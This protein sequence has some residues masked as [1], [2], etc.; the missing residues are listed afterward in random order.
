MTEAFTGYAPRRR[1]KPP[2]TWPAFMIVAIAA[3][4]GA[5]AYG[6]VYGPQFSSGFSSSALT[7]AF[8]AALIPT[9]LGTLGFWC[10]LY[11]GYVRW[12]HEA[13]GPAYFNGLLA[14]IFLCLFLSPFARHQIEVYKAGDVKGM[15]AA[16]AKVNARAVAEEHAARADLTK[17]LDACAREIRLDPEVLLTPGD[18]RA[19]RERIAVARAAAEVYHAGYAQRLAKARDA[20]VTAVDQADVSEEVAARKIADF[21]DSAKLQVHRSAKI[22][23]WEQALFDE[24]EAGIA[25]LSRSPWRPYGDTQ[26]LFDS[27]ADGEAFILAQ[28]EAGDLRLKLQ[29]L[30]AGTANVVITDEPMIPQTRPRRPVADV[31]G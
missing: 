15:E 12:K 26:L 3:A 6:Q 8:N 21:D 9:I 28:R 29:S 5:I 11:F 2:I 31:Y 13:R 10:L 22:Q 4:A 19:A 1:P 14:I 25:A 17:A 23:E 18:R 20:F 7:A 16:V 27:R 24:A 30:T